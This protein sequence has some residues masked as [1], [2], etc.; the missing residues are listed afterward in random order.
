VQQRAGAPAPRAAA[1]DHK[2]W[3]LI[4]SM[5][6]PVFREAPSGLATGKRQP[7]PATTREASSGMATG[8]RQ[9]KPIAMATDPDSDGDGMLKLPPSRGP[10]NVTLKRGTMA[11]PE[12][13]HFPTAQLRD[14]GG[15]AATLVDVTVAECSSEQISLNY[16]KIK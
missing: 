14:D 1:D 12:G 16:E 3:I 4:E 11:C 6:S 13:N 9:H 15:H 8:K 7:E 10:G 2:D 5:A